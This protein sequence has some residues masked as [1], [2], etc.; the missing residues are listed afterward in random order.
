MKKFI[1]ENIVL[2]LGISLP[3]LF[4]IIFML[5]AYVPKF[6]VDN[7]HYDFIFSDAESSDVEFVVINQ[8]L[9]FRVAV[10]RSRQP[11]VIPHLYR[12]SILTGVVQEMTFVTPDLSSQKYISYSNENTINSNVVIPVDPTKPPSND[13]IDNTAKL[14]SRLNK[15]DNATPK[16]LPVPEVASLKIN[17]NIQAPDGYIFKNGGYGYDSGGLL[18]MHHSSYKKNNA[19]LYKEG[20][21]IPVMYNS[22]SE[23]YYHEPHFIGWIIP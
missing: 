5:I 12:Y 16:L 1:K 6:F 13:Q 23:N 4:I 14:I 7:P 3:F 17:T 15:N 18:F 10:S 11:A 9:N 20:K 8:S 22:A 21:S 2:V 19:I